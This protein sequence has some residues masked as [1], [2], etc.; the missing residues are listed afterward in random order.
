[1]LIS[2]SLLFQLFL[3][4]TEPNKIVHAQA[5]RNDGNT[6]THSHNGALQV[7]ITVFL[8][9]SPC[10]MRMAKSNASSHDFILSFPCVARCPGEL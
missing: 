5:G 3:P 8:L 6:I 4:V 9:G 7:R 1:M 10:T 2:I